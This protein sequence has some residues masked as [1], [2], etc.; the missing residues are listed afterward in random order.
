MCVVFYITVILSC[1][2]FQDRS[3]YSLE[4]FIQS[5]EIPGFRTILP[6]FDLQVTLFTVEIDGP[7]SD[8]D[9]ILE[10]HESLI[11]LDSI[12]PGTYSIR[13]GAFN[14]SGIQ[15]GEGQESVVVAKAGLNTASVIISPLQ[16]AGELEVT[17]EWPETDVSDPNIDAVLQNNRTGEHEAV[18]F[19][20][21]SGYSASYVNSSLESGSYILSI[22]LMD[23]DTPVWGTVTGIGVIKNLITEKHLMLGRDQL[24]YPPASPQNLAVAD[25]SI[26][27]VT[28]VF[29]DNSVVEEG[30]ILEKKA[31]GSA[32]F[33][34]L[35]E[36][37]PLPSSAENGIEFIDE[38]VATGE[39][40]VYRV[41]SFN[42]WGGS[43]YSNE[44]QVDIP[45]GIEVAGSI[46]VNTEWTWDNSYYVTGNLVVESGSRLVVHEGTKVY[47]SDDVSLRVRGELDVMGTQELPVLFSSS[48]VS[49]LPGHWGTITFESGSVDAEFDSMGDY[50]SG[51]VLQNCTV[52][53][54]E[55]ILIAD[56]FPF[57]DNVEISNCESLFGSAVEIF[58]STGSAGR[59]LFT[60]CRVS[61]NPATGV[62]IYSENIESCRLEISENVFFGNR[63][64]IHSEN[65]VPVIRGNTFQNNQGN[66]GSAILVSSGIPEIHHN[67]FIDN[68]GVSAL[69]V[70]GSATPIIIGNNFENPEC[71]YD[72][73]HSGSNPIS[74]GYNYWNTATLDGVNAR[75]FDFSDDST[76]G[77]VS[78]DQYYTSSV[79]AEQLQGFP[80][81]PTTVELPYYFSW[82]AYSGVPSPLDFELQV[83][84]DEMFSGVLYSFI[85]DDTVY[86]R[87]ISSSIYSLVK[88]AIDFEPG[89]Y[90]W[91]VIAEQEGST[92]FSFEPVSFSITDSWAAA[93]AGDDTGNGIDFLETNDGNLMCIGHINSNT[94]NDRDIWMMKINKN[95]LILWEKRYDIS[96]TDSV[97]ELIKCSDGGYAAVGATEGS[98]LVIRFDS[99]GDV[100]WAREY[101]FYDE[102]Y[103]TAVVQTDDGGFIVGGY[104]RY[105][106]VYGSDRL[107]YEIILMKIDGSGSIV[108]HKALK[109]SNLPLASHSYLGNKVNDILTTSD[110]NF[111]GVGTY[112]NEYS[113]GYPDN[114]ILTLKFDENGTIIWAFEYKMY[115][116][117]LNEFTLEVDIITNYRSGES[118]SAIETEN[119]NIVSVGRYHGITF[120]GLSQNGSIYWIKSH[121]ESGIDRYY[122]MSKTAGGDVLVS[123]KIGN[124]TAFGLYSSSIGPNWVYTYGSQGKAMSAV[125]FGNNYYVTGQETID[126][127]GHLMMVR[128]SLDGTCDSYGSEIEYPLFTDYYTDI[129][130]IESG[131][132]TEGHVLSRLTADITEVSPE[133]VV[134]PVAVD[135]AE[136]DA[137]IIQFS[138]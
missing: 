130:Q 81:Y 19:D 127:T 61:D 100:L 84:N 93:Y 50:A 88:P 47:F 46:A 77:E 4:I 58:Y 65:G 96:Q 133:V 41:K 52:E 67:T 32:D 9:T 137:S 57:I 97:D 24:K 1:S 36:L 17:I 25:L 128:T 13:I 95:G 64:A 129:S 118:Y 91:N 126:G 35:I 106:Y 20:L 38:E 37:P 124:A 114:D 117:V 40:I 83:S 73:Y 18:V 86:E 121:I 105:I 2:P 102:N 11:Q 82:R 136:S 134:V 108:W 123:G 79:D 111:V 101:A 90:Y 92:G 48:S 138:P 14:Q 69:A 22:Q 45:T 109:N 70:N 87:D 74:A 23:G 42:S 72:V 53:S 44:L 66:H 7:G 33:S 12:D 16:G 107:I 27:S 43:D 29:F 8:Y 122:N 15:I 85:L 30:F 113:D 80:V 21:T 5:Q 3:R 10:T 54:G 125:S 115:Y 99:E 75:I 6:D 104:G 132:A 28:L 63:I 119:G 131:P 26:D 39:S 60:N 112:M 62:H 89:T 59:L 34:E 98:I 120:C 135:V 94:E 56:S 78:I 51:S 71:G 103:G 68:Q 110:G 31:P 49:P 76:F 116:A 55:G